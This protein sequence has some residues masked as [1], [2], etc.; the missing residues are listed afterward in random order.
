MDHYHQQTHHPKFRDTTN[1]TRVYAYQHFDPTDTASHPGHPESQLHLPPSYKNAVLNSHTISPPPSL[2][3]CSTPPSIQGRAIA[4]P[5]TGHQV[6]APILRAWPPALEGTGLSKS[7]FLN[8]ID[9]LNRVTVNSPPIQV[10]GLVGNI[11]GM[12]PLAT[13]QIV[14][15]AVNASAMVAGV[16]VRKGHTEMLLREANRDIFRPLGLCVKLAKMEAV[17]AMAGIP[18][19]NADG[20]VDRKSHILPPLTGDGG[21]DQ[22]VG[23]HQ[24]RLMALEPYISPLVLEGLPDIEKPSNLLAKMH[25]STSARQAVKEEQQ[26]MKKRGRLGKSRNDKEE[27]ALRKLIFLV[28]ERVM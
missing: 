12:V 20:R 17:A 11:V 4:I 1:D 3:V 8:F 2:A 13:T 18:I 5:A 9:R 24:R 15:S 19:V 22:S 6:G 23:V 26:M 10:L 7:D 25:E 14:G 21:V 28:V 16:A 27:K